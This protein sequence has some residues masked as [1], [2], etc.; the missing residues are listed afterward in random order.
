M[1]NK[2][3]IGFLSIL[4]VF[5][6]Y[7]TIPSPNYLFSTWSDEEFPRE[8]PI[9]LVFN[10]ENKGQKCKENTIYSTEKNRKI[11]E[12]E[13]YKFVVDNYCADLQENLIKAIENENI[14]QKR[15]L[16]SL[17]A[18]PKTSDYSTFEKVQPLKVASYKNYQIVKLLLDNGAD[19]NEEFCCCAGCSSALVEAMAKNDIEMVKLLLERGANINYKPTFSL[20]PYTIFDVASQNQ[21]QEIISILD[22]ACGKSVLCRAK[23]RSKSLA[24]LI[25]GG[26]RRNKD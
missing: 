6:L 13:G 10:K 12:N 14:A 11:H 23:L 21:N 8:T 25:G 20:P 5:L 15:T 4:F 2:F 9:P 19:V 22:N 3:V 16:I 24:G 1:I 17:G 26:F 18:N 7:L